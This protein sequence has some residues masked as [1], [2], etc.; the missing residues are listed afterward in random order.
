M[1][2][3][4]LAWG[5]SRCL[6][7]DVHLIQLRPNDTR[8]HSLGQLN[9]SHGCSHR[10]LVSYWVTEHPSTLFGMLMLDV[11]QP[12][13]SEPC[14]KSGQSIKSTPGCCFFIHG[15]QGH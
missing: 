3:Y 2:R 8:R 4:V 15:T 9:G 7:G 10:K 11:L 12:R 14:I 5:R 6:N 13:Q 1:L